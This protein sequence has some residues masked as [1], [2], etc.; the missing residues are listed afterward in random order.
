ME[1]V[2]SSTGKEGIEW[3]SLIPLYNSTQGKQTEPL[4][5]TDSY[6]IKGK[7]Y[8]KAELNKMGYTDEQILGA[9]GNTV[10]VKKKK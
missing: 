4:S 2:T 8:T 1:E 3:N 5:D 10:K 7:S 6:E 9:I